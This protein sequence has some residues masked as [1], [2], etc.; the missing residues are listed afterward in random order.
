MFCRHLKFNT[1]QIYLLLNWLYT[2]HLSR[3]PSLKC[4]QITNA[5][6]N[7]EKRELSYTVG[8]NVNCCSHCGNR[9]RKR[10]K[11]LKMELPYD[12]AIPLLDI[13]PK[14]IKTLIWKDTCTSMFIVALFTIVKIWKQPN[15]P[16]T[17]EWIKK[18]W[19]IYTME[20]LI[21]KN[22]ILPFATTWVDLI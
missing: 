13:Y 6:E 18:M 22:E 21:K 4:L 10:L 9:Y 7:M 19:Y 5:S 17:D 1:L 11:K 16:S 2:S 15:C 14:N 20:Y 8:G 12:P 3:W